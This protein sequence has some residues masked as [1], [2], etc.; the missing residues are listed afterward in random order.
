[1]ENIIKRH[2]NLGI[3]AAVLFAQLMGLAYQVKRPTDQGSMRLIRVWAV[4]A[5]TPFE[6][7]FVHSVDWV[8]DSWH[9]YAYLRNVRQQND[10]LRG[11]IQRLRLDQVRLTE[12]A[13]QARRLQSLLAFKE[14]FISETMAAQVISSTGSEFT[15]GIYIDKG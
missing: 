13:N 7:G 11:E 9:N 1:M 8:A 15:R 5:I 12:D 4:S 6:K 2:W 3:L 10:E 14:Q